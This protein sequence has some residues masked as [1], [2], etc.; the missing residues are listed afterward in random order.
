MVSAMPYMY[1][2]LTFYTLE[3]GS[4][5]LIGFQLLGHSSGIV[6]E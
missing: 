3:F 1:R 5:I 6:M 2:A 4:R